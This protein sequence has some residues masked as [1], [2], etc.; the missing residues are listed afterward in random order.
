MIAIFL[1]IPIN[2]AHEKSEKSLKVSRNC[3]L[4]RDGS[5]DFFAGFA[6]FPTI[7]GRLREFTDNKPIIFSLIRRHF[8]SIVP[9]ST[10]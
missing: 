9:T 8:V 3:E 1:F 4:A 5:N 7:N 10:S 2:A 6:V